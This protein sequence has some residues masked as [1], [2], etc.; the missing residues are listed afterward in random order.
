MKTLIKIV[1]IIAGACIGLFVLIFAIALIVVDEDDNTKPKTEKAIAKEDANPKEAKVDSTKILAEIEKRKADSLATIT[2]ENTLKE[3]G[4]FKSNTD[5]FEGTTFYRDPRTPNYTNR[6]FIYPYIG[7]K[8]DNYWLRLKFQY[9]ASDWLFIDKVRIK[10]DTNQYELI[11][12]F[13]RDNHSEIWEWSD[14]QAGY[15]EQ[16]MLWDMAN[17]K[18][19]T[20]RYE[21]RQYH[22][23]RKLTSKEKSVIA[24]TLDIYTT[25]K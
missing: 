5:E 4:T 11:G 9:T 14:M 21:G 8:E 2:R 10:T 24:K 6:N 1:A 22:K 15:E 13:E 18:D 20:V 3:L 7:S 12:T 16:L 25:L 17:S 19:V 23:D